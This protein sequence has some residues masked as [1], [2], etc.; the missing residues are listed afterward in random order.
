MA[1]QLNE[2]GP[3][4]EGTILF[5]VDVVAL[6][7]SVP[8]LQAPGVLRH[9]LLRAGLGRDLVDWL[10]RCTVAL[11]ECNTFEYDNRLYTQRPGH[12]VHLRDRL[13]GEQDRIPR[14]NDLDRP[15]RLSLHR[16]LHQT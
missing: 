1:E 10:V 6:Y 11:L 12:Q 15:R 14:H 2:A 13:Q 5:S 9:Q 4:P 7:P 3:Q 8:T 16:P